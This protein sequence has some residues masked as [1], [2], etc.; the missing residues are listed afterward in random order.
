MIQVVLVAFGVNDIYSIGINSI[1]VKLVW[2]VQ[3]QSQSWS[4]SA[5]ALNIKPD[6]LLFIFLQ[7]GQQLFACFIRNLNV[8]HGF[9]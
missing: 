8:R 2:L 4:A 9:H 7:N 5:N 1:V 3:S 6:L